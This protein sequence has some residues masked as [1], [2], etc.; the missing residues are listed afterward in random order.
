MNPVFHV[1]ILFCSLATPAASGCGPRTEISTLPLGDAQSEA[2]CF[3]KGYAALAA[4][5]APSGQ[6]A[7]V[8]CVK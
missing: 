5:P 1:I 2:E 6:W 8:I 4:H 7:K 3:T